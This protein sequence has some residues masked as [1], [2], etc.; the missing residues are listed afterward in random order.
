MSGAVRGAGPRRRSI[1][2]AAT[3]L[4]LLVVA[5]L[6]ACATSERSR[7]GACPIQPGAACSGN[8]MHGATLSLAGLFD[9]DFDHAD[10]TAVRMHGANLSGATFVGARLT[11]ADLTDADLSYADLTGADLRHAHLTGADLTGADLVHAR[12]TPAQLTGAKLCRTMLVDGTI[13]APDC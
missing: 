1:R 4:C 3:G 8:Y 11:H 7:I 6:S 9:A 2:V 12:V 13:A 10:L 5:G